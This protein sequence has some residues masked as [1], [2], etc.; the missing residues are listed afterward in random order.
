[1][2]SPSFKPPSQG[3]GLPALSSAPPSPCNPCLDPAPPGSPWR[4]PVSGSP[5]FGGPLSPACSVCS[6]HLPAR[7]H[8]PASLTF[9]FL[10]IHF[11]MP[12]NRCRAAP[13]SGLVPTRALPA[14]IFGPGVLCL[15]T[16]RF[17]QTLGHIWP[18]SH[19]CF[20]GPTHPIDVSTAKSF[21]G[22]GEGDMLLARITIVTGL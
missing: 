19:A 10:A 2:G 22:R 21:G 5:A 13:G 4:L 3:Q 17:I 15:P 16:A 11:L 18:T 9:S 20:I 6:L 7:Y 14:M 8:L 12:H 1:M